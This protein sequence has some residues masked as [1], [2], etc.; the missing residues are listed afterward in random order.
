MKIKSI[1][2]ENFTVFRERQTIG[3][4]DGINVLIGVN[5][6]GKSHLLKLIYSTLKAGENGHAKSTLEALSY[7]NR[8]AVKLAR[9]F[10]PDDDGI[11][12]LITRAPGQPGATVKVNTSAGDIAFEITGKNTLRKVRYEV[13]NAEQSVFLPSREVLAMYEGFLASYERREL[14]FDETYADACIALGAS[15]V[16]GA[17]EATVKKLVEPLEKV[18]G[19]KIRLEGGRFYLLQKDGGKVE[20]HLL[21][22]G[23]RKVGSVI[24]MIANG[25][26]MEN[27]FLFWDEPEANLNPAMIKTVADLLTRLAS[28]GVQVFLATHDYLLTRLLSLAAEYSDQVPSNERCQIRFFGL[29]RQDGAATVSE[30]ATLSQLP[31]N[32]IL[33]EFAALYDREGELLEKQLSHK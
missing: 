7:E 30:A 19:G 18:V 4:C 26:L 5:G 29:A 21:A 20:A 22:E 13:G 23:L 1:N 25:S 15:Q 2:I 24:Q 33:N 3:F 9:V 11:N 12:R 27:G 14:S 6:T 8:L 17:R 32:P 10:K 28:K 31:S 16:R